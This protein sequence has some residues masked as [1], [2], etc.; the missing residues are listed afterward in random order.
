[1]DQATLVAIHRGE[2]H[3]TILLLRTRGS[4]MCHGL[5]LLLSPI[6][7]AL[8]IDDDRIM[9]AELPVDKGRDDKLKGLEGLPMTTDE[10]GKV[11]VAHVENE[12]AFVSLVLVDIRVSLAKATENRAEDGHRHIRDGIELVV[13]KV[14]A[15]GV[16]LLERGVR[17]LLLALR[18]GVFGR[19]SLVGNLL[20]VLSHDRPPLLV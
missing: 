12:L 8:D 16:V 18:W 4:G 5:N 15:I 3:L 1:M 10:D 7:V 14:F 9:E 2:A 19:F 17:A 13:G 6:L 11:S 20:F